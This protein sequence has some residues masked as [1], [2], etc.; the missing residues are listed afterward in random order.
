[1][2][3]SLKIFVLSLILF[4]STFAQFKKGDVELSLSGTVGS[5]T[6]R[7]NYSSSLPYSYN[8]DRSE[9]LNFILLA[10]TGGI[11]LYDGFSFEP[12]IDIVALEKEE[13]AQC[14]IGNVSYTALLPDSKV[15]LFM[16]GGY[17]V[18][19]SFQVPMWG[20][21]PM[22]AMDKFNV[23]IIN[24]G[25]GVK[26]L[27]TEQVALRIELNYRRQS[28]GKEENFVIPYYPSGIIVKEKRG[29]TYSSIGLYFGFSVII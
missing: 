22:G 1:M 10:I 29:Y 11:F 16:R 21:M 6:N 18:S 9:S 12:E 17:G 20:M 15:A 27:I 13:P 5:W 2:K 19:N 3:F 26:Y 14:Y 23:K 24:V 8:S 28:F 25:A 4:S 7:Y